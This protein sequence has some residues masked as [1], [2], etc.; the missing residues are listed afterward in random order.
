MN[1]RTYNDLQVSVIAITPNP[2]FMIKHACDLAIKYTGVPKT[3]TSNL[4]SAALV[5]HLW[6]HGHHSPLEQ[7]H[8]S[9][10]IENMSRALLAQITRQRTAHPMSGSQHY[11]DYSEY[12][13]VVHEKYI[14]QAILRNAL[15]VAF[16]AYDKLIEEGVP[17][18][19]ARMVLP[20]AACVNFL[21]TIDA[22]NLAYF[23]QKRITK[24]NVAEMRH[25]S[26]LLLGL[27]RR[28]LPEL[29]NHVEGDAI[30]PWEEK[31]NNNTEVRD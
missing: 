9:F 2:L 20:Q 21:F 19:E 31:L 17:R 8:F 26:S 16:K 25:L 28:E 11:Q 12:N 23:I 18:S 24:R 29:F 1:I 3:G 5:R 10:A 7:V 4:A 6:T 27:A 15:N 22:R 14:D 30:S 13:C